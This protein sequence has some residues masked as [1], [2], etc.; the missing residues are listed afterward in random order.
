MNIGIWRSWQ[1]RSS[2][3]FTDQKRSSIARK[4]MQS[5]RR[6]LVKGND[7]L[8]AAAQMWPEVLNEPLPPLPLN[9]TRVPQPDIG[10]FNDD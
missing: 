5:A 9:R 8:A 2:G 1:L 7:L 10:D 6:S 4:W 3:S